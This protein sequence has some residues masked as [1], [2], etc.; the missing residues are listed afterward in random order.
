MKTDVITS[1]IYRKQYH[2]VLTERATP[3]KMS[4][5]ERCMLS[6]EG[7]HDPDTFAPVVGMSFDSCQEAYEQY[8]LFAWENGFGIRHGKSRWGEGRYQLMHEI[9]F[10]CQVSST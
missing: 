9:A 3:S 6:S 2:N 4:Y 7:K 1:R 8:N 5:I 10:Q